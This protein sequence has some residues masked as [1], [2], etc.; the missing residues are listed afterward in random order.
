MI[1]RGVKPIMRTFFPVGSRGF[2][3]LEVVIAM[4]ILAIA[5]LGLAGLQVVALRGNS[6]ASQITEATTLAQDQLEQL[7]ATPFTTLTTGGNNVTG[8]T[9]ISYNVQWIINPSP[10]PAGVNS[11]NVTVTVAWTHDTNHLVTISSVISQF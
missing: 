9:G 4:L 3:L 6:L 7:I 10:I 1:G 5:L 2:T 11:A 8:V